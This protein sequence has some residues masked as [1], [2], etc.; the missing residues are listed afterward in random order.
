M[1]MTRFLT[2]FIVNGTFGKIT[3]ILCI[4]FNMDILL[5]HTT[6]IGVLGAVMEGVVF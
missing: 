1:G 6:D 5:T 2:L 3:K 4:I